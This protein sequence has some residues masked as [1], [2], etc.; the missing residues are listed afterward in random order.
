[1]THETEIIAAS[2]LSGAII[3][4]ILMAIM[5]IAKR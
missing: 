5:D 4:A 1:M 2:A 3:G